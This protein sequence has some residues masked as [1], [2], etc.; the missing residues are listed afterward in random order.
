MTY[1]PARPL[2]SIRVP[3]LAPPSWQEPE[4]EEGLEQFDMGFAEDRPTALLDV[5]VWQSFDPNLDGELN[6]VRP[7]ESGQIAVAFFAGPHA[8]D[9]ALKLSGVLR[10]R[11]A[12]WVHL[13]ARGG[14]ERGL[15]LDA[16]RALSLLYLPEDGWS[17][18]DEALSISLAEAQAATDHGVRQE[19]AAV[20]RAI[21]E[22]ARQRTLFP[23]APSRGLS[24]V[25]PTLWVG[26]LDQ[27]LDELTGD[28]EITDRSAL[29]LGRVE[30]VSGQSVHLDARWTWQHHAQS[31]V[32][33]MRL[34]GPDAAELFAQ[35]K[36]GPRGVPVELARVGA[37][38]GEYLFTQATGLRA[39]GMA[40]TLTGG[41]TDPEDEELLESALNSPLDELIAAADE[42]RRW[43]I[44]LPPPEP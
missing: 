20:E 16:V 14:C 3:L 8:A 26:E 22:G 19:A 7:R 39:L 2:P 17:Y 9:L 4:L 10:Y 6:L 5:A 35:L 21:G 40:S 12:D 30:R 25:L 27:A 36:G 23:F 41:L 42:A 15:R 33:A 37:R 44:E 18:E 28:L 43:L 24:L 31:G 34:D 29:A 1:A 13:A 38:D 11:P 32:G